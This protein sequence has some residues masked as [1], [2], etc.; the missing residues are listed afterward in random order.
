MPTE[1][2]HVRWPRLRVASTPASMAGDVTFI[3]NSAATL[4][5]ALPSALRVLPMVSATVNGT[6]TVLPVADGH[7]ELSLPASPDVPI[8]WS[9]EAPS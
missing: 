4:T 9:V 7:V 6:T 2:F 1:T 5:L 3:G 8:A